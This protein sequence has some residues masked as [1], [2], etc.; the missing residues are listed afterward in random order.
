M[1]VLTS[2]DLCRQGAGREGCGVARTQHDAVISPYAHGQSA[3]AHSL[4]SV[5][6]L[7]PACSTRSRHAT[8]LPQ[9]GLQGPR[10]PTGAHRWP[11]GEKTVRLLRTFHVRSRSLT[12][13]LRSRSA[14]ATQE[15]PVIALA[16]AVACPVCIS[17][18]SAPSC[19]Q[20][21]TKSSSL[22]L[23]CPEP[24]HL[25][26]QHCEQP[27]A[28]RHWCTGF[29]ANPWTSGRMLVQESIGARVG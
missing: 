27:H 13:R 16:H 25:Q 22:T 5:L 26:P 23:C 10:L 19:C 29:T 1:H 7:E 2:A 12:E 11:S 28:C 24:L 18:F 15:S 4:K 3:L 6:H 17:S 8:G 9:Q 20:P 14:Q 21:Y